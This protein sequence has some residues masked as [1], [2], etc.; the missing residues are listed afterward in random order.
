M[1]KVVPQAVGGGV[2]GEAGA[3]VGGDAEAAAGGG[4][5]AA[6]AGVDAT[7]AVVAQAVAGGVVGKGERVSQGG[8]GG[9]EAESTSSSGQQSGAEADHGFKIFR[10]LSPPTGVKH[11]CA[12]DHQRR[13]WEL[14]ASWAEACC[15]PQRS[16]RQRTPS[17]QPS[18][19]ATSSMVVTSSGAAWSRPVPHPAGTVGG[20]GP[21]QWDPGPIFSPAGPLP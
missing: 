5:D 20:H 11:R 17:R 14:A 6:A 10:I 19:L 4:V 9:G 18:A 13:C 2:V 16:A 21:R 8:R 7:H 1:H 3:A 12:A 15:S